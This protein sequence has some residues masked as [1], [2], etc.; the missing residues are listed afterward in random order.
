MQY[1]IFFETMK[2]K[3]KVVLGTHSYK[4]ETFQEFN[5]NVKTT[6][7]VLIHIITW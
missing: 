6:N 5:I 2:E 7:N 3:E 4:F 1:H